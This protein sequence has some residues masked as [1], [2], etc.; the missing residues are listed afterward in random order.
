MVQV[1]QNSAIQWLHPATV[2]AALRPLPPWWI[3]TVTEY[4]WLQLACTTRIPLKVYTSRPSH[5]L[6]PPQASWAE[7]VPSTCRI[8]TPQERALVRRLLLLP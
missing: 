1:K 2:T 7:T 5:Q 4:I 8:L 3:N 6:S